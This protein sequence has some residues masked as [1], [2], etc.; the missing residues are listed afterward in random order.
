MRRE[1]KKDIFDRIMDWKCMAVF[2]PLYTKY[3]EALLYI[4]FGGLSFLVSIFSYIAFEQGLGLTP[5]IANIFSWIMAVAFAYITN[6]T[7][8]FEH[9]AGTV[10]VIV[11]ECL[12]FFGGRIITLIMEEI[13]LFIG[14]TVLGMSSIPVKIVGQIVVIVSN[15]FISKIFVFRSKS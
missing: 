12:S 2:R 15:Y 13:I 5:L 10:S 9:I 7:W 6:R 1:N 4:F 11:R 3:K 14:I 8:V